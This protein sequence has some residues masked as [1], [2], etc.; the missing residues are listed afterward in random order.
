MATKDGRSSTNQSLIGTTG[1]DAF[2]LKF[3]AGSSGGGNDEVVDIG[4]VDTLYLTHAGSINT[5]VQWGDLNGNNLNNLYFYGYDAFNPSVTTPIQNSVLTN[6]RLPSFAIEKIVTRTSTDEVEKTFNTAFTY[7]SSASSF[8]GRESSDDVVAGDIN[9][10]KLY[11]LSGDD[12]LMGGG[13]NDYLYG[14]NGDDE[15]DGGFG[16]D[17]LEGGNGSDTYVMDTHRSGN[18]TILDSG[19]LEDAIWINGVNT[20]DLKVDIERSALGANASY[21]KFSFYTSAGNLIQ[22]SQILNQYN[23][24]NRIEY[25]NPADPDQGN[26]P[27]VIADTMKGKV[28]SELIAGTSSSEIIYANAGDDNVFAG[29]G[30]DTVYGGSGND[31]LYGGKSVNVAVIDRLYGETGDDFFSSV[32][33]AQSYMHGGTG[34]DGYEIDNSVYDHVVEKV[35]EGDDYVSSWVSFT[36]GETSI[37]NAYQVEGLELLG[38]SALNGTG[39]SLNNWIRGNDGNN[40]LS[41]MA[42]SDFIDGGKGIDTIYGGTGRDNIHGGLGN[43]I[44]YGGSKQDFYYFDTT[45]NA[46]NNVDQLKDFNPN[47]DADDY[48]DL[49][50]LD[51]TVFTKLSSINDWSGFDANFFKA[52]ASGTAVDSND[53]IVLDNAGPNAGSLYYDADGSG[54]GAGTKFAQITLIG[55]DS[56]SMVNHYNFQVI[57]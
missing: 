18:D 44:I 31:F 26:Q 55:D 32:L 45:L 10:N 5:Q 22:T 11:G 24:V 29:G 13:G 34:N 6:A 49:I 7:S 37:Q 25:L 4:G 42:G 9:A 17:R 52:N 20:K 1:S 28:V 53:Y 51:K 36:L 16:N 27:L 35:G 48:G 40:L 8:T 56:L 39:N 12:I 33:V 19:G 41:G 23:G 57:S 15:L 3:G 21:L 46:S 50:V 38:N 30:A 43:D 54:A 2:Y 47:T 14:G